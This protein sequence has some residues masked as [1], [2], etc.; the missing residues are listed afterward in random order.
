MCIGHCACTAHASR[1]GR[2]ETEGTSRRIAS[3]SSSVVA[4]RA[5]VRTPPSFREPASTQLLLGP[6]L[7]GLADGDDPHHG[8]R[9]DRDASEVRALRDL[10]RRTARTGSPSSTPLA[11]RMRRRRFVREVAAS[12]YRR[13]RRSRAISSRSAIRLSRMS[14]AVVGNRA[15]RRC[16]SIHCSNRWAGTRCSRRRTRCTSRRRRARS[17]PRSGSDR[18]RCRRN[19][20]RWSRHPPRRP[21]RRRRYRPPRRGTRRP[22]R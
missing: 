18:R 4:P 17:A 1:D 14:V 10:C 21:G 16:T 2:R 22:R 5:P 3:A 20:R 15:R 13:Q 7:A 9:A 6:H 11:T 8:G 19:R 12:R